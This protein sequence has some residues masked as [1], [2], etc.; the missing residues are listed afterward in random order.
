M[1]S[2]SYVASEAAAA[3][4]LATATFASAY[5]SSKAQSFAFAASFTVSNACCAFPSRV[6][7]KLAP[8]ISRK[9][10]LS[11][12]SST[13]LNSR[14]GRHVVRPDSTRAAPRE[15]LEAMTGDADSLML[16]PHAPASHV[17]SVV[18][19]RLARPLTATMRRKPMTGG[20]LRRT[21]AALRAS[22]AFSLAVMT[23]PLLSSAERNACVGML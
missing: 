21:D 16:R 4:S 9:A 5:R 7:G 14:E 20:L 1:S 22:G 13:S 18:Q 3:F 15:K 11:N 19:L 8:V 23:S 2:A 10:S 6:Q 12:P 17:N